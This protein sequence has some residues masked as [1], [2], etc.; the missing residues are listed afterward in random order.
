ML[1]N[2]YT[3][4]RSANECWRRHSSVSIFGPRYADPESEPY[5]HQ[6][7]KR[8]GVC[9]P[10][11]NLL[12]HRQGRGR[13]IDQP[14][15]SERGQDDRI[16]DG[17]PVVGQVGEFHFDSAA[18]LAIKGNGSP[19]FYQRSRDRLQLVAETGGH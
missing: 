6:E 1:C 12:R 11:K 15:A 13:S 14:D 4:V 10:S 9:T 2:I 3:S 7:F 19:T 8:E 17:T 16:S 5:R 18:R